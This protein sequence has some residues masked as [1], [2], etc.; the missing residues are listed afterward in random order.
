[1]GQEGSGYP[2]SIS[3]PEGPSPTRVRLK[4]GSEVARGEAEPVLGAAATRLRDGDGRTCCWGW[5]ISDGL[6][7]TSLTPGHGEEESKILWI[8][9]ILHQKLIKLGKHRNVD[10]LSPSIG[11]Q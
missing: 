10:Y 4:I 5:C 1:M 9:R 11:H 2:P 6:K 7:G 3:T 8:D